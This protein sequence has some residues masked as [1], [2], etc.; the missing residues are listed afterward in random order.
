MFWESSLE[1]DFDDCLGFAVRTTRHSWAK[2]RTKNRFQSRSDFPL[3]FSGC[4]PARDGW[5]AGGP[6]AV[7]LEFWK[8]IKRNADLFVCT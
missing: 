4:P 8:E 5:H 2:A 3:G 6:R 1:T 7:F